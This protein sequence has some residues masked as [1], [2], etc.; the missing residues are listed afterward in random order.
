MNPTR[1]FVIAAAMAPILVWSC[2]VQAAEIPSPDLS[3]STAID[4]LL[5]E[6]HDRAGIVP[7]RRT[8]DRS[9]LRRTTLDLAGRIPTSAEIRAY[10]Q[11]SASERQLRLVD[12]LMSAADYAIHLRNELDA[13]LSAGGNS[14][15]E[16]KDYL[17][18]ACEENQPWDE[19]FRELLAPDQNLDEQRGAAHFLKSRLNDLDD[20]TND[21][22][23]LLLG[24]SINCAKCHDHP[25]VEDW[26]QDHYFGLQA[27]LAQ[28]YQTRAGRLA[29]RPP[30]ELNFKTTSGVEKAARLMFLT[31][32][33]VTAPED[34]RTDEQKKADAEMVRNQREKEGLA[35]PAELEFSPRKE[36][37]KLALDPANRTF[38]AR[39]IINR[40]W[41]RLMG[42]GLVHP[43]DQMHSGN[44]SN[45]PVL[46]DWLERDFIDHGFDLSRLIRGIVL[47]D[48]YA[49]SSQWVYDTP[50]PPA[51]QFAVAAIKPLTPQQLTVSL[52]IA[53]MNPEKIPSSDFHEQGVD[54]NPWKSFRTELE[55]KASGTAR[56]LEY[57]GEN[58]QISVTEALLFNNAAQIQNNYLKSSDERL[59]NFLSNQWKAQQTQEDLHARSM[60]SLIQTS[61]EIVFT[62]RAEEDEVSMFRNYLLERNERLPEAFQQMLW[63][64]ITSPEFRFN[65]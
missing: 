32:A 58:F 17:L 61:F 49:R 45:H 64:M 36:F 43:V 33:T 6:S 21:T 52:I 18:K 55:K 23:S 24:V 39:S 57:P 60:D 4:R 53:T 30:T 48:A 5:Q 15:Q 62:R 50:A 42:R 54:P 37:V 8:D 38:M 22:S 11:D 29:E 34:K 26:K 56:L 7:A 47:S 40:T 20:L 25:L 13:M 65:Y 44:P 51:D 14:P 10:E 28:T 31:G 46:L 27:F 16:W 2:V 35:P 12:R 3:I 63:A 1:I 59:V 9:L 41:A 19:T